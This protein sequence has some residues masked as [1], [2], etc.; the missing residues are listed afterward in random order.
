[1]PD[2]FKAALLYNF[3]CTFNGQ[4]SRIFG[5][6]SFYF[7]GYVCLEPTR[8]G[9]HNIAARREKLFPSIKGITKAHKVHR[10]LRPN[11]VKA[12]LFKRQLKHRGIDCFY[13][14]AEILLLSTAL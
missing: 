3:L 1:M 2:F 5:P 9:N 6:M 8:L 11:E 10:P 14:V 13:P 4:H 7:I 12:F